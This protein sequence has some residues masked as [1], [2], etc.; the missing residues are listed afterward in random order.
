MS[1]YKI[2]NMETWPR[3]EHYAFYRKFASPVFNITVSVKADNIYRFAKARGESFFLLSLYAILRAANTVPQVRQR[4]VGGEPVEF[5][6]IAAM[7][8]IMT[9]MEMFR[10]VWCEYE[11]SFAQFKEAV[12]PGIEQAGNDAPAPL[13]KHEQDF[14][15][16]SCLP[17][18]RFDSITQA[19]YAFDQDVPILAWGKMEEGKIPIS[20]KFNHCFMDGLHVSRFFEAITDGFSRPECL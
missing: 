16:A 5:D 18:L 9:K 3:R 20:V 17:W 8:P 14:I 6:R 1:T 15:C 12:T 7:T 11:D 4:I 2:I 13:E 19:D 10:Q